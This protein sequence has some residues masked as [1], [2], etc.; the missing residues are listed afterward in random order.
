MTA[1][2]SE[3][4]AAVRSLR[5][6]CG[7]C[8]ARRRTL[9]GGRKGERMKGRVMVGVAQSR[10]RGGGSGGGGKPV[11]WTGQPGHVWVRRLCVTTTT[12][13]DN[14]PCGGSFLRLLAP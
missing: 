14:S 3:E 11:V 6:W 12:A 7:C 9:T 4:M 2:I 10:M 1:F 13:E 5:L 8:Q